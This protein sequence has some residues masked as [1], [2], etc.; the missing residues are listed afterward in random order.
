MARR[1][2]NTKLLTLV[3]TP[4]AV[5][6]LLAVTYIVSPR[7]REMTPIRQ[8][9]HITW[10]WRGTPTQHAQM[11]KAAADKGDYKTAIDEYKRAIQLKGGPDSQMYT[12]LGDAFAHQVLED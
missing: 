12:D 4:V 3:V 2:V 5:L 6:V 7:F 1:R 8:L 9:R 11:A 10:L